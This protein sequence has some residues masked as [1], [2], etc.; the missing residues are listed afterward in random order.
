MN[1]R[2]AEIKAELELTQKELLNRLQSYFLFEA[3]SE[4]LEGLEESAKQQT[5]IHHI[6]EDLRDVE[7]ALYK[8]RQGRYGICE[9]T[10]KL[11]PFKLLKILPTARTIYDFSVCHYFERKTVPICPNLQP[12]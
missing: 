8:M 9:E 1:D 3:G 10:G 7:L 5:L 4:I 11:I 6:K 2:Y 12:T